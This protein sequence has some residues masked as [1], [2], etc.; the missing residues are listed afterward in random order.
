MTGGDI[1][2]HH[3]LARITPR[4]VRLV[5][6]ILPGLSVREAETQ[7]TVLPPRSAGILLRLLRS[8][9]ANAR[10]NFSLDP[11]DLIVRDVVVNAG[12]TMKRWRPRARGAANRIMKRTA[13]ITIVV[14][15]RAPGAAPR[16][17]K[18]SEIVTKKVAD[19]S[20][21][22]LASLGKR[23]EDGRGEPSRAVKPS[24]EAKGLRHLFHRR[25]E[26]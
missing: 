7:L 21:E 20:K 19:L 1:V 22:E 24:T 10:H 26:Q 23:A 4:K 6:R 11:A 25:G 15:E 12:G 3:R 16:A 2:A 17:G 13:N 9:M 5:A 18:K 8:A 14:G